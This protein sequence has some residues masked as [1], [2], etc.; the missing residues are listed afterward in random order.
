[1]ALPTWC[2]VLEGHSIN[3]AEQNSSNVPAVWTQEQQIIAFLEPI[4]KCV[5][6]NYKHKKALCLFKPH[7]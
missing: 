3:F 7:L 6:K 4:R 1:M 2:R 5:V